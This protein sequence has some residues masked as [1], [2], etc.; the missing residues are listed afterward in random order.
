MNRE[1]HHKQLLKEIER[2]NEE[3]I[4]LKQ[5]LHNTTKSLKEIKAENIDALVIGKSKD[6]RIYA[7][8]TA[9]KIYRI[10]IEKMHEGA[11]I[12]NAS[13]TILY[14]NS[15][16]ATM[17][18]APLQK[19]IGTKFKT[20][21][22]EASDELLASLMKQT[23]PSTLKKE[24]LIHTINKKLIPVL[25]S[26]NSLA[27]ND[28]TIFSMILTDLT[29]QNNNQERLK[30]KAKLLAAQNIELENANKDLTTFTFL[31][32]HDLQEPLRK[33][34]TF[35]SILLE[36]EEGRLSNNGKVYFN[37]L[38]ESAKRMRALLDDLL[39]YSSAKNNEGGLEKTDLTAMVDEIVTDC[40]DILKEKKGTVEADNLG[41]AHIIPYQFRQVI[42]NLIWNSIKFSKPERALRIKIKCDV[43]KW[44]KVMKK[45]PP[46][47]DYH[48]ITYSDNGIG[49]EPQYNERVFGVFQ[50]LHR[51]E[52]YRGTGMGLAICKRIIENHH[53]A[54]T[55]SGKLNKGVTFDIY[56]PVS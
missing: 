34:Q 11:V 12:L 56:I 27:M 17:V 45:L 8:Q 2:L 48:H 14:C 16:F 31:S 32:S 40:E 21:I 55:A 24:V 18:R 36:E 51:A 28:N 9:D 4:S 3:T 33:I 43:V 5:Q 52:K 29:L 50:R 26:V 20:Y 35:V 38:S 6:L 22:D 1:N 13:G 7:E 39:S 10:L 30:N 46:K 49:F 53:G 15:H 47:I 19:I 41:E 25:M 44:K 42:Y 23:R 54:I 37:K